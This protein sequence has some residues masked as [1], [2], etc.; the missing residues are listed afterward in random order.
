[1]DTIGNLDKVCALFADIP[2]TTISAVWMWIHYGFSAYWYVVVPSLVLWVLFEIFRWSN[3]SY[4]SDNGFT[5][6][7]NSFVGGGVFLLMET[8]IDWLLHLFLGSG[9]SCGL[10][11]IRSF[12]LIPFIATGLLLHSIGFWPYL[13]LPFTRE[14]TVLFNRRRQ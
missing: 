2:H 8:L 10:I 9:V 6:A 12:Y 7:F 4:N 14:K 5:P 11:W 3:H 1:M 13:R